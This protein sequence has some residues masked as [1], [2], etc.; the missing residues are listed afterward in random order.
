MALIDDTLGEKPLP[1][2][3]EQLRAPVT[4]HVGLSP[5]AKVHRAEWRKVLAGAQRL[6]QLDGVTR[7]PRGLGGRR[8]ASRARGHLNAGDPVEINPS[9]GSGYKVTRPDDASF[10]SCDSYILPAAAR[11]ER[12]FRWLACRS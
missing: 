6:S 4:T 8:H 9:L 11:R 12:H 2:Y 5:Y 3:H 7:H 10:C 1:A